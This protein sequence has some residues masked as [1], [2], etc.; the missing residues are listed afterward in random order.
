MDSSF[1]EASF[2]VGLPY[3]MAHNMLAKEQW[4]I[5]YDTIPHSRKQEEERYQQQMELVQFL[6]MV[7]L[8]ALEPIHKLIQAGHLGILTTKCVPD[9]TTR[10]TLYPT[11]SS[12]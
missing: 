12:P 2:S 3:S 7:T 5:V 10:S 9:I 11:P 4:T 6:I 8:A 1:Y